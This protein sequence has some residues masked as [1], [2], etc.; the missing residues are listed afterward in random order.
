MGLRRYN[1]AWPGPERERPGRR[2]VVKA[3]RILAAAA[4]ALGAAAAASAE[5]ITLEGITFSDALGGIVLVGGWSRGTP[6]D[7]FDVVEI[8]T[9]DGPGILTIGGLDSSFGNRIASHHLA[10][11]TLTKIVCNGTARDWLLFDRELRERP[12]DHSPY[13]DGLSFGQGTI[14]GRH[15]GLYRGHHRQHAA[16]GLLSAAEARETRCRAPGPAGGIGD[17]REPGGN[18]MPVRDGALP[19]ATLSAALSTIAANPPDSAAPTL[20]NPPPLWG[21]RKG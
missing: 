13:Q 1:N 5:S 8:I 10:G 19:S 20:H 17:V 9:D 18:Q 15:G 6:E 4:L 11:F 21:E 12:R 7:P 14:A 3:I 2:G 16:A